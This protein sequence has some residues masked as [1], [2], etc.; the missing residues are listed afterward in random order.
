[1]RL[2]GIVPLGIVGILAATAFSTAAI[3]DSGDTGLGGNRR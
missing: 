1:M 2:F 3:A